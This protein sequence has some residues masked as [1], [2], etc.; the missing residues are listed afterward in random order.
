M[1]H[2]FSG[3]EGVVAKAVRAATTNVGE[4]AQWCRAVKLKQAGCLDM[5][6]KS[7]PGKKGL[8]VDVLRQPEVRQFLET[9]GLAQ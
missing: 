8:L 2:A 7:I 5:L 9:L 1:D 6:R 3:I 4:V